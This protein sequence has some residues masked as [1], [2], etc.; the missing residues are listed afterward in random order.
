MK[1]LRQFFYLLLFFLCFEIFAINICLNFPQDFSYAKIHKNVFF[2]GVYS[3]NYTFLYNNKVYKFSSS[4]YLNLD[5][6]SKTQKKII[7]NKGLFNEKFDIISNFG[8]SKREI[9]N[10]FFP[11]IN[12][13]KNRLCRSIDIYPEENY[14]QV[15]KNCCELSYVYGKQGRFL[16]QEHFYDK[17]FDCLENN[18]RNISFEIK[19]D[20]YSDINDI[21]SDFQ[22][23]SCFLTNFVTSSP[24]RKNNIKVAL[25]SFDGIVLEQGEVLSF[26]SVTGIRNEERGYMPAKIISNGTFIEGFG[27][28]VCQVS[29]TLY[30]AC[31]LAGLDILEVHNHSL[32]ISYVEPSFDAMVN[33]GSSDLVIR[34]NTD[35]KIIITT[36]YSN[37]Q[38]KVKIFGKKNKYK[39]V[40]FSDKTSVIPSEKDIVETNFSKYGNFEL[41]LGEEKRLSYPKDGYYSKGYL[42]YYDEAGVLIET[43]KI[44]EDRYNPT[45]GIILKRE[46]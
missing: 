10:Y 46:E 43:K 41:E 31:L 21:K 36:S 22:E 37:D 1:K 9:V 30:N 4:E 29:T 16:N 5:N 35:G 20:T 12:E 27:G 28:G 11:E 18:N 40:R 24:S 26:N 6:L 14:V 8:L 15:K 2:N 19:V 39:I 17:L 13:I 45:K 32:P 42:K 33:S 44:R 23:K 38:C 3:R 25:S 34:N 7:F